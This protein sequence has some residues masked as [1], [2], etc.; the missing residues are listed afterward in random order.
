MAR[1]RPPVARLPPAPAPDG[2]PWRSSARGRAKADGRRSARPPAPPC[3]SPRRIRRP[4][5]PSV[6]PGSR[7]ARLC[8]P[9]AVRPRAIH[10]V[11][12][13][14]PQAIAH[15]PAE[16]RH[17][18]PGRHGRRRRLP[19]AAAARPRRG[20]VGRQARFPKTAGSH[21][22]HR[23]LRVVGRAPRGGPRRRGGRHWSTG[24]RACPGRG[25][26][27]R[28][29]ESACRGRDP[30]YSP[31]GNPTVSSKRRQRRAGAT[32]FRRPGG[33]SSRRPGGTAGMSSRRSGGRL[34]RRDAETSRSRGR[35]DWPD[36]RW[37]R[38]S[39]GRSAESWRSRDH[40]PRSYGR[41]WS[42]NGPSRRLRFGRRSNAP[43]PSR[44][45]RFGRRANAPHPSGPPRWSGR[46]LSANGRRRSGCGNS[47]WSG[48]RSS[49]AGPAAP[50][51]TCH[52]RRWR[53]GRGPMDA[54]R[55]RC[56]GMA[57]TPD[58]VRVLTDLLARSRA[59]PAPFTPRAARRDA[60]GRARTAKQKRCPEGSAFVSVPAATYSPTQLPGQYHR[61]WRA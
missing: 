28:S 44:P 41:S 40:S 16:P 5:D 25:Q 18:C 51:P 19:A 55:R 34:S 52:G 9:S 17:A 54:G 14:R 61:R 35:F 58:A 45:P 37:S 22:L 47:V 56:G 4:A 43:D 50:A 31:G 32:S 33:T 60:V 36:G 53:T 2:R 8:G 1:T 23:S 49:G 13:T 39:Q 6:D 7:S 10:A 12:R 59:H 46:P 30:G 38:C 24:G 15:G 57:P 48:C 11:V 42:A 3:G 21:D 27:L 29:G 20:L 26:R